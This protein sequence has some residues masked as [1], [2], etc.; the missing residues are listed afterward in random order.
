MLPQSS[1]NLACLAQGG[2]GRKVWATFQECFAVL[3]FVSAFLNGVYVTV[4]NK[5]MKSLIGKR[6]VNTDVGFNQRVRYSPGRT[7][8]PD[9]VETSRLTLVCV[10]GP[11]LPPCALQQIF[12]IIHPFPPANT[13][14]CIR[15]SSLGSLCWVKRGRHKSSRLSGFHLW[16]PGWDQWIP[17]AIALEQ[18]PRCMDT[19]RPWGLLWPTVL[20][21]ESL[22]GVLTKF[23]AF[24]M[25]KLGG[26]GV[27]VR[28]GVNA[29]RLFWESFLIGLNL[30]YDTFKVF[31]C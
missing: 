26:D 7:A 24:L 22:A 30:L 23:V 2:T 15:P 14:S 17:L 20:L 18:S 25:E 5:W 11:W 21:G 4:Y 6:K 28:C 12:S 29:G 16:S 3:C 31:T 1:G 10:I 27:S 9:T 8:W 13:P 19:S